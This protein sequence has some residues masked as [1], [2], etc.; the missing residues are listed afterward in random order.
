MSSNKAQ[1]KTSMSFFTPDGI[2]VPAVTT[3]QMREIDRIAIEETGPNLLQMMEDAGG[4][5]Q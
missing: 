4:A 2:E 3:D 1:R 5:L